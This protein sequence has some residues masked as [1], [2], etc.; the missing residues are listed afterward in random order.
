[1]ITAV[2]PRGAGPLAEGRMEELL[3]NPLIRKVIVLDAG[4]GS[5]LSA[6]CE[7]LAVSD[8][9]SGPTWNTLLAKAA[10][11][12]LLYLSSGDVRPDP[13]APERLVETAEA[14]G[15]GMVYADYAEIRGGNILEHP[16]N[17]HQTGSIRDG[18]DFGPVMLISTAAARR[19]LRKYGAIPPCRWAGWYDLRLKLSTDRALFRLP[20]RISIVAEAAPD[21]ADGTG[22]SVGGP[23]A[24]VD[25]GNRAFQQEMEAAA[26]AHLRR[27]GAW[28]APVFRDV[29]PSNEY[30]PVEASVVIPVRNRARTVADAVKSAF[31]QRTDFP[32]NVIAVDNH[33]TD[34]TTAILA[35]LAGRHPALKH[36]VPKRLDLSIGGCWNEAIFSKACGRYAVQLDSDDLYQG[37]DVLKRL[38]DLLRLANCALVV[39]AYTIVDGNLREIPPGLIDHREW[40]DSNGRNNALRINGLGAP[41]AFN[42]AV[43]RQSG[44][45]NVGYGED[46]AAALRLS[47]EY[48]IGRIYDSLYLCRRWEGNTDAALSIEQANLHDAYK[49][50]LRTIEIGA[51]RKLNGVRGWRS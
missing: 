13:R 15:A 21:G 1:M 11:R 24:Y 49:D 10:T 44:F 31:A 42:T 18:F 3:R 7:A 33:S 43:L 8:P 46:Y 34:G 25:P 40:T 20:E 35:E 36:V 22:R 4:G 29:S 16:V 48:R 26:T 47:R 32:F 17:D 37:D 50:R 38:I 14:T 6:R 39:G 9:S 12:Y 30:F 41:R 28:L 2:I 45:P 5:P 19:A 51:R 23:F 27:I